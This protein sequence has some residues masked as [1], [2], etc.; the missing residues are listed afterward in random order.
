MRMFP[1]FMGPSFRQRRRKRR[2]PGPRVPTARSVLILEV[3]CTLAI[4]AFSLTGRRGAFFDNLHPRADALLVLVLASIV[5]VVHFFMVTRVLPELKR[6]HSPAQYDQQRI[7]LDLNDAA[8]YSNNL[9]DVYSFSVQTIARA[10]EAADVAILV[11]DQT[12]GT[13]LLRSSSNQKLVSSNPGSATAD[14]AAPD[15][16]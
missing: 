4:L 12:T 8:R 5:G 15:A 13:L 11:S 10:L 2:A 9:T 3:L 16:T 1:S 6:R 7:L 14:G